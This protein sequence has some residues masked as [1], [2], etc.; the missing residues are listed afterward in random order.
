MLT[1]LGPFWLVFRPSCCIS[2]EIA[3]PKL[4][5]GDFRFGKSPFST[6]FAFLISIKRFFFVEGIY[7]VSRLNIWAFLCHFL[8]GFSL[9]LFSHFVGHFCTFF[10]SSGRISESI[11]G[12][13]FQIEGDIGPMFSAVSGRFEWGN[14]RRASAQFSVHFSLISR[15][16]WSGIFTE[17]MDKFL[18]G[19]HL[20]AVNLE[21]IF[22]S[23]SQ[24]IYGR[25]FWLNLMFFSGGIWSTD[26]LVFL[27][28]S[29]WYS[30]VF[31]QLFVVISKRTNFR[32]IYRTILVDLL[33]IFGWFIWHLKLDSD[34]F[35]DCV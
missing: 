8:N 20:T 18:L 4:I 30:I 34:L 5:F 31:S 16:V 14:Y 19:F 32:W 22:E 12:P 21:L 1:I 27:S 26:W 24:L 28:F 15:Q 17:F 13:S 10:W 25:R 11:F 23:I 2:F 3:I 7:M 6:R 35:L 29:N 9:Q 33:S